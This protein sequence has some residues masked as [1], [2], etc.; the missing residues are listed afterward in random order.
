[1]PVF[2]HL[3]NCRADFWMARLRAL[4]KHLMQIAL[5]CGCLA[6]AVVNIIKYNNPRNI[7]TLGTSHIAHYTFAVYTP[8]KNAPNACSYNMKTHILYTLYAQ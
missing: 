3:L 5:D 8:L 6:F 7:E 2:A 1:M 4:A